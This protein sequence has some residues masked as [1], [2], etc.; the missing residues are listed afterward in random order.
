MCLAGEPGVRSFRVKTQ[1]TNN[2]SRYWSKLTG[3]ASREGRLESGASLPGDAPE[4]A[5][6]TQKNHDGKNRQADTT[7]FGIMAPLASHSPNGIGPI[8]KRNGSLATFGAAKNAAI[9]YD[10]VFDRALP[11]AQGQLQINDFIGETIRGS[12]GDRRVRGS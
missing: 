12:D 7:A 9:E 11:V 5:Y 4:H 6:Q 8:S 10:G 1:R 3:C 2:W